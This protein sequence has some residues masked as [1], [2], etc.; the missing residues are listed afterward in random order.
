MSGKAFL[1]A[2]AL[3][4]PVLAAIGA[5][6]VEAQTD[7]SK[8]TIHDRMF[9]SR[10]VEAV[11]WAMPLLNFKGFRDGHASVGVG[12]NDIAYHSK[13]QDWKFQTATPNNTTPYVNFYW[14]IKDGPMVVE[15]PPSADGVGI[16]GTI[17]DAWQRPIDDVGAKGRDGGRGAKYVL[18]PPGY[19]GPVLPGAFVYKQRTNHGFAVLRA[20]IPDK[21]PKTI[22][23]A[24]G[25]AKKIRVYPLADAA[26]P[27]QNK[28]VDIYGKLNEMTPVLDGSI[29]AQIHEILQEEIVE[30]QNKAMMGLLARIGIKKGVPFKPDANAQAVFNKAAPDALQYMLEQYHRFLNPWMYKNKKWSVLAPPGAIETDFSY[31]FPNY[32]DYHARG[33]LYYAVITSVKNYGTA[34]FYLDIAE[35]PDGKWLDGSK[36][37]KLVVPP[38]VPARD[39]WAVTAYDLLTASYIREVSKGSVDS[40]QA[41]LK[42]NKDGSVDVHLGPK[43]PAGKEAN[44]IPTQKGKRFFLLFRFY[45]PKKGVYDG[46]FELNDI[47]LVK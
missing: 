10:A 35:T 32:F 21:D 33:A 8:Q 24:V 28:Y 13:I 47:E 3:S 41:D 1:K 6:S 44:W 5:G 40:N 37:Y 46:S 29:F 11:V 14:N 15:V 9:H 31:E 17:M 26:K 4:F 42:K 36:N 20:I 38:N 19:D 45:G 30:E 7:N 12:Y 2:L 18:V 43:A 27:P 25:F 16:F 34:T 39:F 22:A 23:K